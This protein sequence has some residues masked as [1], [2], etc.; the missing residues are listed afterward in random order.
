MLQL[1]VKPKKKGN[2]LKIIWARETWSVKLH[3]IWIVMNFPSEDFPPLSTPR[4]KINILILSAIFF[5]CCL[6]TTTQREIKNL[7]KNIL[8]LKNC[9]HLRLEVFHF[10]KK[11]VKIFR[12][13]EK[14]QRS[15]HSTSLQDEKYCHKVKKVWKQSFRCWHYHICQYVCLNS[16]V[17]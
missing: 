10:G 9:L 8:S 16:D 4:S 7:I 12:K 3:K 14:V 6:L 5:R 13:E 2:A 15:L 11:H 17:E 1:N